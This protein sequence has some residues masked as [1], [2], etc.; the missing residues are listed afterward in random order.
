M[1]NSSAVESS[2]K[3]ITTIGRERTQRSDKKIE[4]VNNLL[5]PLDDMAEAEKAN[6]HNKNVQAGDMS[7][8][9]MNISLSEARSSENNLRNDNADVANRS[10]S[11]SLQTP[12]PVRKTRGRPRK[13]V[14]P[15]GLIHAQTIVDTTSSQHAKREVPVWVSLVS[16]VNQ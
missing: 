16:S 9:L 4:L 11:P 14:E 10:T 5:K 6:N 1:H 2:K 3:Q 13:T 8:K 7:S 12:R 15:Q